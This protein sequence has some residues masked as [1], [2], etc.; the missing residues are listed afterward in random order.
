MAEG[1]TL[2]PRVNWRS[3]P[4]KNGG[5]VTHEIAVEP[6]GADMDNFRWRV[7]A[8]EIGAP[9]AFSRFAGI[10]RTLAVLAG[11]LRLDLAAASAE[12][13][14][15]SAPF[16]FCG[17]DPVYGTPLGGPVHDLNAMSR[18]SVAS[19]VVRRLTIGTP[20]TIDRLGR[21]TILL[22][23]ADA[24]PLD[25]ALAATHVRLLPGDAL[26]LGPAAPA[27][28]G[29]SGPAARLYLIDMRPAGLLP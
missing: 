25:I 6:A 4:W 3:M 8:A 7:S 23:A 12:L 19:H 26:R 28:L 2:L 11:R 17:D 1:L 13:S 9:G 20:L 5:G 22:V 15:D 29:L 14:P 18:R 21:D 10:D 16:A 24:P 27:A